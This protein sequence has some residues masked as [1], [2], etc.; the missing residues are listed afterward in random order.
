MII[1]EIIIIII[2]NNNNTL[3][4]PFFSRIDLVIS[5]SYMNSYNNKELYLKNYYQHQYTCNCSR[6][7]IYCST[8]V[9][10]A[11]HFVIFCPFFFSFFSWQLCLVE[12]KH[13]RLIL[14]TEISCGGKV[15]IKIDLICPDLLF[16]FSQGPYSL[17]RGR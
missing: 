9:P 7:Y 2:N 4:Y 11:C 6:A 10:D 15:F 5:R 1:I 16:L 12:V 13:G 3:F 17:L 14:A 8:I